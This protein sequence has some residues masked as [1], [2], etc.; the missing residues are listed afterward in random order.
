MRIDLLYSEDCPSHP[1]A[2]E[3]LRSVLAERGI[4]G[5]LRL[6]A[7]GADDEAERLRF[8]GSPTIRIDGVDVDPS[9]A[10]GRPSLS[11]RIYRLPDG[12]ISPVP[13]RTQLEEAFDA[14]ARR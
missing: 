2:L 11:C 4:A 5:D 3:L 1:E 13:A 9:G 12:R 10:A 6:Q 8:P 7:V 14:H